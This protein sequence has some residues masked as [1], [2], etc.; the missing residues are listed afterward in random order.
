MTV[1]LVWAAASV[2]AMFG[3]VIGAAFTHHR[4]RAAITPHLDALNKAVIA[5]I[6]TQRV[7]AM[8]IQKAVDGMPRYMRN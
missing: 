6:A 1:P 8:V 2:G 5:Y 3:Y 7:S 4:V